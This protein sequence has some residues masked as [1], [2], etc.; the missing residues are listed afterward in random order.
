MDIGRQGD[1]GLRSDI[2]RVTQE[3]KSFGEAII[4][5]TESSLQFRLDMLATQM[6]MVMRLMKDKGF[7]ISCPFTEYE[8]DELQQMLSPIIIVGSG[9]ET[10][11]DTE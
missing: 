5:G 10:E 11:T 9:T 1:N 7:R 2:A 3:I 4:W 8:V 6:R